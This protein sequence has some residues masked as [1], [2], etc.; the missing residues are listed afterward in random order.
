MQI[1][2]KVELEASPFCSIFNQRV[3]RHKSNSHQKPKRGISQNFQNSTFIE[4]LGAGGGVASASAT[5]AGLAKISN[6]RCKGVWQ[7][8]CVCVCVCERKHSYFNL[9]FEYSLTWLLLFLFSCLFAYALQHCPSPCPSLIHT[10]HFYVNISHAFTA[11]APQPHCQ[12]KWFK[13]NL[14]FSV[15]LM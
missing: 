2:V 5:W 1:T 6:M 4:G 11:L 8:I 7:S 13:I 15:L 9:V 10:L 12:R 14:F 3:A